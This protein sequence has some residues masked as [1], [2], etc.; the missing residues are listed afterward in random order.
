MEPTTGFE[1]VTPSLP[2]KCST[3]EPR[4]KHKGQKKH[5]EGSPVAP[6]RSRPAIVSEGGRK[7]KPSPGGIQEKLPN[8][9]E[10][11]VVKDGQTITRPLR[12]SV[13]VKF[14]P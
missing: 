5:R 11:T 14:T 2:R 7:A 4:V 10:M 8:S 1:P 6:P 9:A 12:G 3:P 13:D